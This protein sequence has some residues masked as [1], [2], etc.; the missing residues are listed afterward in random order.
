MEKLIFRIRE[1]QAII[2]KMAT[3]PPQIDYVSPAERAKEKAAEKLINSMPTGLK[4]KYWEEV[5]ERIGNYYTPGPSGYS[6]SY[7]NSLF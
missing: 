5:I 7:M 3:L 1:A 4:N 6:A 2:V